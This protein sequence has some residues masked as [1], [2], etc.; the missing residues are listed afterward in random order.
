MS[1]TVTTSDTSNPVITGCPDSA[2]YLVMDGTTSRMVTWLEPT[3]TDNSGMT[4]T[5]TRSH[6]PGDSFPVGATYVTYVFRDA[7]GNG[8]FCHF[9][10]TGNN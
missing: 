6:Q 2:S 1:N 3:A 9:M 5:V 10:I 7:A 8:D 4:P